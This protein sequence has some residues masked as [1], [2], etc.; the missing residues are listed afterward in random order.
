MRFTAQ[1][2]R[3]AFKCSELQKLGLGT[4]DYRP[5]VPDTQGRRGVPISWIKFRHFL[6]NQ[7]ECSSPSAASTSEFEPRIET[8][9]VIKFSC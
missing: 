5:E 4:C 3:V 2:L 6:G 8:S 9:G 7:F 1:V